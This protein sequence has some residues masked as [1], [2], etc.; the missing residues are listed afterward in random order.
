MKMENNCLHR[1]LVWLTTSRD[2]EPEYTE[3]KMECV[4][5]G[6]VLKFKKVYADA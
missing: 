5:C 4:R 3:H 6:E 1:T 2:W